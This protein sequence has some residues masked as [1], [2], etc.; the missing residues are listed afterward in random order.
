M[1][2]SDFHVHTTF[3]DG[4]NT[5]EEM[6]RAA[7]AMGM[8]AIGFSDHSHT[9]FDESYCIPK[10]RVEV[11]RDT[12]FALREKYRG[13]I[14][15]Y[16]GIEQDLFSDSPTQGFDYVIGSVHYLEVSG[17]Y[18]PVDESPEILADIVSTC[19]GGNYY[20]MCEAYFENVSQVVS[21]TQADIIGHFDLIRKFNRDGRLFSETDA[22]YLRAAKKAAD[23]LLKT[24]KPFE[25]NT[26]AMSRGYQDTP[27]PSDDL[28]AYILQHGGRFIASSD[29]HDAA[30]LCAYFDRIPIDTVAFSP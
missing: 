20:R 28:T 4:R 27:Y 6:V 22:R 12:I 8:T 23:V 18:V 25:L 16:C 14:R 9:S 10:D 30:S 2:L 29:S 17:R 26:G 7:I 13:Q 24:G 1:I 19:F 3:S 21:R 15:I 5:P 11:Y